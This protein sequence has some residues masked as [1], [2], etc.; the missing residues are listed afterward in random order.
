MSPFLMS[1]Q[2]LGLKVT[3][4]PVSG[5]CCCPGLHG[6]KGEQECA[7]G[8]LAGCGCTEKPVPSGLQLTVSSGPCSFPMGASIQQLL[9]L[10]EL[11]V[12]WRI[13]SV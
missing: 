8:E 9:H 5:L 13:L 1:Q 10:W 4:F 6:P 2:H 11:C 3:A 12:H 7:P